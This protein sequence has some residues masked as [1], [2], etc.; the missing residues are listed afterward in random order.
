MVFECSCCPRFPKIVVRPVAICCAVVVLASHIRET[1]VKIMT[2]PAPLQ[3]SDVWGA[4]GEV[5]SMARAPSWGKASDESLLPM[6]PS[7]CTFW[8]AIALGALAKGS[9]VESV[10]LLLRSVSG[11][12]LFVGLRAGPSC[13]SLK[14]QLCG[15]CCDSL[16]WLAHSTDLHASLVVRDR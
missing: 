2:S 6:D 9:P 11:K 1:M 4:C 5:G 14:A 16:S 10:R 13:K 8:C 15:W 7:T 3:Q 12:P